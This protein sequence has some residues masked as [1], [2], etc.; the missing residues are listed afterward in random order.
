MSYCRRLYTVVPRRYVGGATTESLYE[1]TEC[2][3]LGWRARCGVG[4]RRAQRKRVPGAC[5]A[6]SV[7][8]LFPTRDAV[9]ST[10]TTSGKAKLPTAARRN[11]VSSKAPSAVPVERGASY[12]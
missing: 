8:A 1:E 5:P 3:A 4:G 9:K 2:P 6:R 11:I 10:Q 12:T 7:S